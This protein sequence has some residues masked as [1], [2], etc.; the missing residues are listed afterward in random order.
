[1]ANWAQAAKILYM[2]KDEMEVEELAR[3]RVDMEGLEE[4][5]NEEGHKDM[6][7]ISM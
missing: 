4:G 5:Q 2:L 3:K 6:E 1:M 7:V